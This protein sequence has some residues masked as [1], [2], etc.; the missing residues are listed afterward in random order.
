M[1]R[2]LGALPASGLGA[3]LDTGHVG[4][5]ANLGLA[6]FDGWLAA[7]GD[8]W[9]GV[10][11]HDVVGLRDHLAP[12]SGGLDFAALAPH[13]PPEAVRTCEVDWYL[14][15]NEIAEGLRHLQDAGCVGRPD[16]GAFG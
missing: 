9:V 3:W 12:G 16:P 10:H 4:A 8:R 13:L 11:F 5:L 7:A 2:L 1:R 14:A 6:S 15:A